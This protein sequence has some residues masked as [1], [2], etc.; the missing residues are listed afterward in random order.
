M[1]SSI[2]K[3]SIGSTG[4]CA[5]IALSVCTWLEH[6]KRQYTAYRALLLFSSS[7]ETEN[8]ADIKREAHDGKYKLSFQPWPLID[9]YRR[10]FSLGVE[11]A[12]AKDF[13]WYAELDG[14]ADGENK[15]NLISPY[16][17]TVCSL[18][19][20]TF[21]GTASTFVPLVH[22]V[23]GTI[24]MLTKQDVLIRLIVHVYIKLHFPIAKP[25]TEVWP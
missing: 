5:Q 7:F 13:K 22:V 8:D 12:S 14:L 21:L 9:V 10:S 16:S 11:M 24:C 1:S 23:F 25:E 4:V 19:F 3:K 15:W 2:I 20:S 17:G 18:K 6:L